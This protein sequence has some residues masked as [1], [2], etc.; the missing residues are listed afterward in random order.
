MKKIVEILRKYKISVCVALVIIVIGILG[1]VYYSCNFSRIKEFSND[2]Y[3]FQYDNGWSINK[4][5]EEKVLLKHGRNAKIDIEIIELTDELKYSS[6][7]D[8]I[9][10]IVYNIE[11]QNKSYKLLSKKDAIVSKY[12]YKGFKLLYENNDSQV[13]STVY[14]K[15]DKLI[16]INYEANIDYFDILLDSVQSVIYYFDVKEK[17]YDLSNK[18]AIDT[19]VVSYSKDGDL[20]SNLGNSATYEIADNNYYVKYSIPSNFELSDFDSKTNYF[21]L[22]GVEDKDIVIYAAI[23]KANIFEM[24]DRDDRTSVY[25]EYEMYKDGKDYSDFEEKLTKI[26]GKVDT[27]LYKN[28]YNYDKA[29]TFDEKFNIK[30]TK[31]RDE[32]VTLLYVLNRNHVLVIKVKAEGSSI[33]KKLIDSICV[34]EIKNY[35]SYVTSEKKNGVLVS[36]LKRY[37]D[38]D[39]KKIDEVIINLP[40][41]YHE[42]QKYNNIYSEREYGLNYDVDKDLYDYEIRYILTTSYTEIGQQVDSINGMF[43]KAYGEYHYLTQSNDI[44]LNDYNFKVYYGGYTQLGGIMLSNVNRFQYYI[45]K[46]VL[47]YEIPSGGYLVIEI[48]G[49]GKDITDELLKDATNFEIKEIAN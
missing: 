17:K 45:N 30:E 11:N 39:K 37:T 5:T 40:D 8:L 9:D 20:D 35:S 43:S 21:N 7:E 13:M 22:K 31:R 42:I 32:N 44:L 6:I 38:Y 1:I 15:S 49:N 41:K 28:S 34:N 18:I 23:Y 27:Y 14:K 29:L 10:E 3:S 4:K 46:K 47:F 19:E 24:L 48:S 33:T 25:S 12:E 36:N 16:M 2:Y 26:D